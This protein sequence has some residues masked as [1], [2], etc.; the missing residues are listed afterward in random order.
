MTVGVAGLVQSGGFGSYSKHYGLAAAALLEAELVT[1]DGRVLVAN[2]ES[3]PDLFW[4]L[5]GGGGGSLAV[6]TRLTLKTRELPQHV[7]IVSGKIKAASDVAYQRLIA[8][9]FWGTNYG[10]LLAV[11]RKYDA[12]GLFV[13]HHGVG[14]ED[15]SADGFTR[16]ISSSR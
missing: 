3:H 10:R 11:K 8:R 14:S 2:A 13:V 4:G 6:V 16:I 1:A 12:H 15:W 9:S 5:K 7:G